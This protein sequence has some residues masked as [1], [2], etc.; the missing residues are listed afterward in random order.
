MFQ[1]VS[2]GSCDFTKEEIKKYN[3]EVIPFYITFDGTSHLKEGVDISKDAYFQRLIDEK[4]LFPKTSQPSPQDYID[5][6]L[7]HLKAGRDIISVTISSKLSGSY[8]SA[9]LAAQM[10]QTEFP[11][12]KIMVL[13]TLN[14]SLCHGIILREIIRMRDAG[15]SIDKTAGIAEKVIQ[16][17]QVYFTL[18][19]LEYL[20]RGGRVGPTTALVGGI[21]G[22]RPILQLVDGEVSQLDNVRGKKRVL[23]LM[24][25][26]LVAALE[27]ET[28]NISLCVG[29]IRNQDEATEFQSNVESALNTKFTNPITSVGATIGT[30][31]GPGALA[32]AYCRK[33]ECV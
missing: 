32:F 31:A 29:H 2:D 3:I 27:G 28:D 24:E 16:S 10:M 4:N 21:L 9:T 12:R 17:A 22:L 30:H 7:P 25:D 14:V 33:Y 23:K 19:T 15:Y 6:F 8:N 20:K 11:E 26:A 5:V 13:D 1:I 18:E